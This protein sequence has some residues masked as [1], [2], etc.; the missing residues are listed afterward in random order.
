MA[1]P[2]ENT[3][4]AADGNTEESQTLLGGEGEEAPKDA[5]KADNAETKNDE[6]DGEKDSEATAFDVA[7]IEMP[8]GFESLDENLM[9]EFTPLAKELNLTQEQGQKFI[10]MHAQTL[11][12]MQDAQQKAHG[13]QLEQW[14]KDAKADKEFGGDKFDEN[15][16][17]ARK[18]IAKFGSPELKEMLDQSGLGNHPE[19]IRVFHKIGKAISEDNPVSAKPDTGQKKSIEERLYGGS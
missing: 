2:A 4:E 18:A 1:D 5:E 3:N 8:E 9:A 19:V 15:L 14:A 17:V 10:S 11:K 16:N 12:S 6:G 13:E 7:K